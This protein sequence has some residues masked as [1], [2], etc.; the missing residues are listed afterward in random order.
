MTHDVSQ[1][2][3]AFATIAAAIFALIP[4]LLFFRNAR[5][6][7]VPEL[8]PPGSPPPRISLLIPARDEERSIGAALE[9]A[10]ASTGVELEVVVL[11]DGSTDR[12]ASIVRSFSARD[13][14]VRLEVAPPLP[15][16]LRGKPHACAVLAEKASYEILAFQDADVRLAPDGLAR[17]AGF[18]E[19]TGAGLVSGF[20]RQETGTIL[21]VLLIP[22]M[23]WV[24]LGFLPLDRMRASRHPAYGAACG[25]LLLARRSAYESSGGHRA[26]AAYVHDALKLSRSFR[27]AGFSTDLFDAT[28]VATC[29]MYESAPQVWEGLAKNATEGMG[30]PAGIV[31]W[32]LVLGLGQ[33]APPI[34]L[35]LGLAAG[36]PAW[37]LGLAA[38]GLLSG[39]AAR[40]AAA[41]R[42]RQPLLGALLH[43]AG[44][45]LFLAIQWHALARY[46]A[47]RPAVWKGR[48]LAG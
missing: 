43:P 15:A 47:G 38:L 42:F 23:H 37:V 18:L 5:G 13:P 25:Q 28:P 2:L 27:A 41:S 35:G 6:F 10:L 20:P 46:F 17:A 44:I 40:L 31:P 30:S 3:L 7:R 14:R 39:W 36:A 4:A 8:P 9:A 16:G 33:V 22:L 26:I 48:A 24:L 34:L 19:A 1:M 45:A 12:T 21:E 32:T 29:R 11:D